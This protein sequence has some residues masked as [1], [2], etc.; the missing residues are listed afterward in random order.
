VSDGRHQTGQEVK[1]QVSGLAPVLDVVAEDPEKEHVAAQM[2]PAAVEEHRVQHRQVHALAREHGARFRGARFRVACTGLGLTV[3]RLAD[4]VHGER[5]SLHHFAGD[6][7]R[8]VAELRLVDVVTTRLHEHE[9]GHAGG[10]QHDGDHGRVPGG[11]VVLEGDHRGR[12]L[13]GLPADALASR[14]WAGGDW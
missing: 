4:L 8:L 10:D 3:E 1:R 7:R 13:V 12:R 11:V 2:K 9:D 6:G 14:T 5:T